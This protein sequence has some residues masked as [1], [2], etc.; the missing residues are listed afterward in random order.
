M[1]PVQAPSPFDLLKMSVLAIDLGATKLAAAVFES[2]GKILSGEYKLLKND[3]GKDAG[4]LFK[5]VIG[6][7]I[8]QFE[9]TKSP[10]KAIGICVPGIYFPET[11]TVW[12]P[13]IEGWEN[14]PLEKTIAEVTSLPVFVD[15]DRTCCVL[16]ATWKGSAVGYKNVVYLAVGT[17]IGA[18]IMIDGRVLYGND[19]IA[20]AI[21]WMAL[22]DTYRKGY[23]QFGNFEYHASGDGIA[24]IANEY[25]AQM[26]DYAGEMQPPVSSYDVFEAYDRKDPVAT[27]VLDECVE[28][29]GKAVANLVSLFNP[30]IIVL[31]GG[32]FGPAAQF[33]DR[34]YRES[35]KWA[36]PIAVERVK[37]VNTKLGNETALYGAANLAIRKLKNIKHK[38][39]K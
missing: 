19:N 20:G 2:N 13:N 24:R 8:A 37:L 38:N 30:E 12:A 33:K 14:Y 34:I 15:N 22:S 4:T 31:G 17:G 26:D 18:G 29:W 9:N 7:N 6:R 36:Q 39:E 1:F 28:F 3:E 27:L 25:L 5:E 23:E 32:V 35:K 11:K 21:G 16:G 10:V